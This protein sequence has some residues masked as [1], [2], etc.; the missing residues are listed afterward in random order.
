MRKPLQGV[1]VVSLAQQYPGPFATLLMSDLGAQ[2]VQVEH[3]NGDPTRRHAAFYESVNRNKSGV[4]LDLKTPEG[5]RRLAELLSECDIFVEGFRPGT[6]D[7][8]GV[9]YK[10]LAERYPRLI[11]VSVSAFGQTGP[12]RDRPAHD[13][14][15]QAISGML[16]GHERAAVDPPY[17]GHADLV[18]GLFAAFGAVS[19]LHQRAA[20][21][22]GTYVDVAMADCL[23]S[24]MT[25][26]VG[27]AMNGAALNEP[28][29]PGYG[30]FEC[31]DGRWLTLSVI[32]EEH[33]WQA[34]VRLLGLSELSEV[35]Y[36]ERAQRCAELGERLAFAVRARPRDAWAAEFDRVGVAWSPVLSPIEVATDA[37][38]N[39]RD[40]FVRLA[41]PEGE[42]RFVAQPL[43]FEGLRLQPERPAPP[44]RQPS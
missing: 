33:F 40:M 38:F 39:A 18:A 28:N 29:Q 25:A 23:V 5:Q 15:I 44:L 10:A 21:G 37:H 19:A 11:Y 41:T 22:N 35:T 17:I 4:C 32:E 1:R 20:T 30:A 24:W 3:P 2:V 34:L 8:L 36:H 12:Y 16:W 6:A 14:S 43:K 7:R 42:R 26:I 27:P 13:L 9:G 31:A